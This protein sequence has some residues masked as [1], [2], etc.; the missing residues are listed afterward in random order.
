MIDLLQTL[1]LMREGK[2][3]EAACAARVMAPV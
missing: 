2:L 3:N 1:A